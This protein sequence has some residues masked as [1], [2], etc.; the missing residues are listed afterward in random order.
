M[1]IVWL[2]VCPLS[3]CSSAVVQLITLTSVT[4]QDNMVPFDQLGFE[5]SPAHF[6]DASTASYAPSDV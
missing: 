6:F 5:Y 1:H 2:C 4:A 3:Y